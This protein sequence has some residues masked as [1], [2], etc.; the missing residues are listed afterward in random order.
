MTAA[1]LPSGTVT[2]VF[3]D[4]EGSTRLLDELGA[5]PYA[6]V[7]AEH[8]R[9][10]RA[11]CAAHGGVEVDTQGDAFFF[12]FATAPGALT[13]AEDLTE[14]LAPG[15]I[16]VRVGVHTGTPLLGKEGYVG[17]DV[18]RA[19][20]IGAAGHGGQVLV[21]VSTAA[22]VET[23]L[24]DLGEH[25]F[26]DLS[27]PE[28]VYQLGDGTFPALKSLYKTTLPVPAT[29]FVGREQ[30]VRELVDLLERQDVRLLT[31]TGPGG[32]GKTRLALQAAAEVSGQF[33]DGV[34]WVALAPLRDAT[35]LGTTL[36]QALGVT[37][38]T[39]GAILDSIAT[40]F[41][42]KRALLVV[43][44]C[45]HLVS[46]VADSVQRLVASCPRLVFVSTSRERLGLRSE[47][48]HAVP[49]M[50]L[51]DSE[52]LFIERSRAV[53]S[54]FKPDE[55]VAAVCAAVD[56]LPLAVELAAA[57]VRS[58][59]TRTLLERLE[60]RLG[61]LTSRDRDVDERQR[62][63][64]A[65]ITWSY[66]LLDPD[67]QRAFRGLSVFAGGCTLEAAERVAGADLD[68]V[69]SLLD[70]SLLRHRID[71]AEQDRYW[72][73]ETI[74]EY[75]GGQLAKEQEEDDTRALYAGFSVELAEQLGQT[76]G[77]GR[78]ADELSRFEA[79]RA[80]FR[81]AL[82]YAIERGDA[83]TAV[84]LVRFLGRVW[85]DLRELRESYSIARL[86]LELEGGNDEDRAYA[87]FQTAGFA[88]DLGE[89]EQARVMLGEAESLLRDAA[90]LRGLSLISNSRSYLD[91][92][93]GS[94]RDAIT[95]AERAIELAREA[96]DKELESRGTSTLATALVSLAASEDV[97]DRSALDRCRA[98][99]EARLAE[100]REVGSPLAE[101]AA[102]GNLSFTLYL[103]GGELTEA[104]EHAQRS[105]RI[106]LDSGQQR[107]T[108]CMLN[109]GYIAAGLGQHATGV[110]LATT[111][112]R[113][114]E[115]EGE[116]LQVID[117]RV[118]ERVE[119]VAR[120]EL[121][122]RDYEEA[123]RAGEALSSEAAVE[124]ALSIAPGQSSVG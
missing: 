72:M 114:F 121:G 61:V 92:G 42:G 50:T 113:D 10:I 99:F 49:P 82:L 16:R 35:L 8:R 18:H 123:V 36:A 86:A 106:Q 15:P 93:V 102:L 69:E 55:H 11:A 21:S 66:E 101:A 105:L 115:R 95:N 9:V 87:L 89:I 3:T 22:L 37:E 17:Q 23:D 84:R 40:A 90:D 59:S 63:L 122:D 48:V 70:K 74:R 30:E 94:F 25:R 65:T 28:R 4:V 120:R 38:Q 78:S 79:N 39:G 112:R 13:A 31:L 7:L 109:V 96:G 44:N 45:E 116:A 62:T 51:S 56:G 111:G 77:R 19:A 118:L 124:L 2:F 58:L 47:R 80:N 41:A 26:K 64:E 46:A 34:F 88:G 29:P 6:E 110:T 100:A 81:V 73:L 24:Q 54:D 32:T 14:A 57:R 85:Y 108:D 76:P 107:V 68:L 91:S 53:A 60:G 20:R 83:T 1:T 5:E 33:P 98:L 52:L 103:L 43:D 97:P 12:A 119:S 71:E 67:E 117:R 104:L 75:A 27:A